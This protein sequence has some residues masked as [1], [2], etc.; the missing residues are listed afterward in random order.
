[1][2][3]NQLPA[4]VVIKQGRVPNFDTTNDRSLPFLLTRDRPS[5]N[6]KSRRHEFLL[7]K[8]IAPHPALLHTSS[9]NCYYI[10]CYCT[11]RATFL[12]RKPNKLPRVHRRNKEISPRLFAKSVLSLQVLFTGDVFHAINLRAR[13]ASEWTNTAAFTPRTDT[14]YR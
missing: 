11:P 10:L 13:S 4:Q 12:T 7:S 14:V 3:R 2:V 1:M 9:T 8:A 5:K 6:A